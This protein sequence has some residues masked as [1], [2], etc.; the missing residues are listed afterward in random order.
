MLPTPVEVDATSRYDVVQLDDDDETNNK[1]AASTAVIHALSA[2]AQEAD[3]SVPAE[4]E[5]VV[6]DEDY[7]SDAENFFEEVLHNILEGEEAEP[8]DTFGTSL[9]S[10]LFST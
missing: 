5:N 3:A 8:D 10:P 6:D 4:D 9:S 2:T 1:P 7:A